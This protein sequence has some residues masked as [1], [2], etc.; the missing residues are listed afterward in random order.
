LFIHCCYQVNGLRNVL[1]Y[2][3]FELFGLDIEE[4]DRI[5]LH[6]L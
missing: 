4:I 6:E 2:N 3:E 1:W 5:F